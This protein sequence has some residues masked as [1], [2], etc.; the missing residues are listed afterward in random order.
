MGLLLFPEIDEKKTAEQVRFF[1]KK[2][3]SDACMAAG[4][5][6]SYLKSPS[7]SGMPSGGGYENH[8]EDEIVDRLDAKQIVFWTRRA[9]LCLH[10]CD[11][12]NAYLITECYIKRR[13]K[14][15]MADD[16]GYKRSTLQLMLQQ[17]CC[18][19]AGY[20]RESS[21]GHINLFFYKEEQSDIF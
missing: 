9:L 4:T 7:L 17:A 1:L 13:D 6:V 15:A 11:Q 10:D 19:L 5:P 2:T 21:H 16:L 8:V 12:W 18:V 3:Y 14:T 20:L